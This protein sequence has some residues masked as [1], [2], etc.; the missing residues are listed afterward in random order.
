MSVERAFLSGFMRLPV[1]TDARDANR[2]KA[3]RSFDGMSGQDDDDRSR[4]HGAA[5]VSGAN[6][7]GEAVVSALD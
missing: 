1:V 5:E 6:R 2:W 3:F 7:G 4:L